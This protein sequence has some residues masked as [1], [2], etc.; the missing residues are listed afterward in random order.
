MLGGMATLPPPPTKKKKKIS[1]RFRILLHETH[2]FREQT[3][4]AAGEGGQLREVGIDM[5]TLLYLTGITNKVRLYSTG[6]TAQ[7]YVAAWMGGEF[8]GEW[9]HV[10][11]WLSHSAVHLKLSQHCKS[12]ILQ[13]KIK[14]FLKKDYSCM[15][16][17]D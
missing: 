6:N 4:V 1:I 17:I 2:R 15:N 13:Y 14:H 11:V 3:L 5:S 10:Y 12:A 8:G 9:I 16:S 7:C